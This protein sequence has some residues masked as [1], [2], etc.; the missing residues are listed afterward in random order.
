MKL[1][2]YLSLYLIPLIILSYIFIPSIRSGLFI[3]GIIVTII[4]CLDN[5]YKTIPFMIKILA[6]IVHLIILIPLALYP[7]YTVSYLT[8]IFFGI[9]LLVIKHLSWWPYSLKR[10]TML[11]IYILLFCSYLLML[12]LFPPLYHHNN[13]FL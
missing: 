5:Y 2:Q 3:H 1:T 13:N 10:I 4:G 7:I 9:A 12:T 6:Y 11:R 8:L